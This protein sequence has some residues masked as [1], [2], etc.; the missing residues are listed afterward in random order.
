MKL[1][2]IQMAVGA[3]MALAAGN[4]SALALSTINGSEVKLYV[5]G[6]TATD[7]AF[8]NL[9]RLT[10]VRGGLCVDGSLDSYEYS[11]AAGGTV[12]Q[13]LNYCTGSANAGSAA[14]QRI[15]I[16]KE[17][18][19]GSAAGVTPVAQEGLRAYLPFSLAGLGTCE[20]VVQSVAATGDFAAYVLHRCD[21]SHVPA[22]A[23][24]APNAGVSDVD[25]STFV[26]LGGVT[27]ADAA[28]LIA[29]ST[30]SVS[31]NPIVSVPFYRALQTAQGLGT[32]D[33]L[34]N[35]PSLALSQIRAMFSGAVTNGTQ[36][37]SRSA[38]GANVQVTNTS[39]EVK[40]CR[41]GNTSG[42]MVSFKI[43]FLGEGCSKNPSS[44]GAF[45]K[46][47]LAYAGTTVDPDTGD[48]IADPATLINSEAGGVTW[49]T[50]TSLFNVSGLPI[51]NAWGGVR[52]FAGGGSGDVR[53]CIGFHS[54]NT[55]YAIGTASTEN[56]PAAGNTYRYVRIDGVEPT[57]KAGME[58]RYPYFTENTLN[59]AATGGNV[60]SGNE[61]SLY[62]AVISRLGTP[63]V[64]NAI[65]T[66]WR[67]AASIGLALTGEADT[68]ILDIPTASNNIGAANLPIT[69]ALPRTLPINGQTRNYTGTANNCNMS[70][71]LFP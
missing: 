54:V 31:F 28:D 62:N 2:K 26:G 17:S 63:A 14:G 24:L 71:Q 29:T 55:N 3:A 8:A 25:P 4:A 46:P 68:G 69:N 7:G 67:D 10:T 23:S 32:D 40:V 35:M 42:T 30:V 19:S 66:S 1:S 45:V 18:V 6:A 70:R 22:L 61:L 43:L 64:I 5:S 50:T 59:R 20:G 51:A 52:V 53:S 56:K 47:P 38:S 39:K 58:G 57:L 27:A 49:S 36:L 13:R 12:T 34:A 48:T 44:I 21:S 15:M 33:T 65:N 9:T 60:L 16:A 41:R 37:W 11:A